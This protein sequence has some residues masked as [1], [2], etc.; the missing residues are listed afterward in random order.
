[1]KKL[2]LFLT[3]IFVLII[4]GVAI[5]GSAK[6]TELPDK[7]KNNMPVLEKKVFIHYKK[8]FAKPGTDCGN[9]VC[10][11]SE[12]A[13]KCPQDCSE[14]IPE[15]PANSCY[16]LMGKNLKLD[17][18]E[19]LVISPDLKLSAILD[20]AAEWD[21]NTSALLFDSHSVDKTADWDDDV[22]DGRNEFSYGDYPKDG[23]IAVTI[24]WGYFSGPPWTRR[25]IEFDIMFDTDFEWGNA[26]NDSS[27]MDLQNIA[28]HEIGHGLGL[29][30]VY[31]A[32][33]NQVTMYGYSQ[34]GEIIKR[35]LE[36]PD[37]LGLQE[38]Y[39]D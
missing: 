13:K 38:L 5:A 37:I 31:N 18:P 26:D 39:G 21:N 6:N 9:G 2:I 17:V 4:A 34:E 7:A 12:N 25:I 23:V 16:E 8:G 29:A 10:E 28:T 33:C 3:V 20:S 22:P 27:L 35:T 1:M 32:S 15:E 11:P 30:D 19:N 24:S 14:D 36:T